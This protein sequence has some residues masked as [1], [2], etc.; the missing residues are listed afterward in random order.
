MLFK[1][2]FS[3]L[4]GLVCFCGN[5]CKICSNLIDH[6]TYNG[7]L[8]TSN[9]QFNNICQYK[10]I[11]V[12]DFYKVKLQYKMAILFEMIS[13][14]NLL[15]FIDSYNIYWNVTGIATC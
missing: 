9:S 7:L 15:R 6:L 12:K 14:K 10:V 11:F 4:I 1:L 2:A 8:G 3:K 5:N 13:V